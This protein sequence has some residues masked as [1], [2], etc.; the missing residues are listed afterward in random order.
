MSSSEDRLSRLLVMVPWVAEHPGVKVDEVCKHFNISRQQLVRDIHLILVCGIAPYY[1]DQMIWASI[2]GE[3]VVISQVDYFDRPMRLTRGEALS[4]LAA[5][6]AALEMPGI[7]N[8]KALTKALKKIEAALANHSLDGA[9]DIAVDPDPQKY[10]E[11]IASAIVSC[12]QVEIEYFG[13]NRQ[14]E[15]SRTVEP[16]RLF[17]H[18]GWWY[19]YAWCWNARDYRFFRLDRIRSI[20][21]LRKKFDSSAHAMAAMP[22]PGPG[23]GTFQVKLRMAPAPMVW[24]GDRVK[25]DSVTIDNDGWYLVE[26]QAGSLAWLV[27]LL[28]KIGPAVEILEP[29]AV[30]VALEEEA[31]RIL[32]TYQ[33]ESATSQK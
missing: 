9:L 10:R 6:R 17:A 29:E 30:K 15:S 27:K 32:R 22:E 25:T 14:E 1:P 23:A 8:E 11:L 28:L 3:E 7:E 5:G 12:E 20:K 31:R 24:F 16:V 33:Q 18:D 4:V 13:A 19:L 26:M 21:R 2:E